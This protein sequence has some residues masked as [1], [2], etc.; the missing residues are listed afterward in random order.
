ML[1]G[2]EAELAEVA[3]LLDQARAGR[4]GVLVLRGEA[5]IGKSA[6]LD[7]LVRRACD[8]RVLRATG[9]EAEA[10][11]PFAG[12]QMLLRPALDRLGTL[13]AVQASALRG[14]L[15]LAEATGTSR[16]L[17]GL[18]VL[19]LL[20]E[21][22]GERPVA[23]LIDD[24]HW[25]DAASADALLFTARRVAADGVAM[26][27]A[28]RDEFDAP[29]LPELRLGGLDRTGST[30]PINHNPEGKVQP[31]GESTSRASSPHPWKATST[32]GISP[33]APMRSP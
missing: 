3:R 6:L 32:W 2:R 21:L 23:C 33:T 30:F 5:G 12:L 29:G 17:V 25:L 13:P 26:V 28:A 27:F 16:F 11:L 22:A 7:Q 15:G 20:S 10:S 31:C 24:A 19:S 4:S 1:R 18:A 9:V 14:A 8:V